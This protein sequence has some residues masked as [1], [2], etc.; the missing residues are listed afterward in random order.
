M[1]EGLPY[2]SRKYVVQHL[3]LIKLLIEGEMKFFCVEFLL[4]FIIAVLTGNA[5]SASPTR[6][7]TRLPTQKPSIKAPTQKPTQKPTS[8]PSVKPSL[9]PTVKPT[10]AI[11][12]AKVNP[13][14]IL[15]FHANLF[16]DKPQ[17]QH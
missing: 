17:Q 3:S 7:P 11:P 14:P 12:S 15:L 16:L 13:I 1:L 10:T 8:K 9:G 4:F 6:S 2:L 5:S